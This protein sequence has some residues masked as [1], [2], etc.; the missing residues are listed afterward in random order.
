MTLLIKC[1]KVGCVDSKIMAKRKSNKII[2]PSKSEE[3]KWKTESDLRVLMQAEEIKANSARLK[4]AQI[5]AKNEL[6][7]ITKVIN[8][9]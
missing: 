8:K 5:M 7:A 1:G 4:R 9:K 2:G 3:L 6:N